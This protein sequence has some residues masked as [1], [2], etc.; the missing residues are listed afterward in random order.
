MECPEI[1]RLK[2]N[3]LPDESIHKYGLAQKVLNGWVYVHIEK[4]MYGLPQAGLL[5]NKL[6]AICLETHGYYQCQFTPGLWHHKCHP[7]T[8]SLV[9]DNFGIKMVDL[10]HAKH[11]KEALQKYYTVSWDYCGKTVDLSMPGYINKALICFQD[12][13]PSQPQHAP[14]KC[15]P[16]HFGNSKQIPITN[17]TAS[18]TPISNQTYSASCCKPPVLLMSCR[19]HFGSSPQ[20]H[21]L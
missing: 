7:V 13:P 21:S 8:F 20:R 2:Y 12:A 19:S 14:Y 5:A 16:I 6:L 4:G 17:T 15:A 1:M 10:T 18:L 9:V 11:L 3:I